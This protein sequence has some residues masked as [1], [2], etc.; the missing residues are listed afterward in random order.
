M[1][2]IRNSNPNSTQVKSGNGSVV[3]FDYG[4]PLPY[5]SN[6]YPMTE[7]HTILFFIIENTD[8]LNIIIKKNH[9]MNNK[10][11]KNKILN[12]RMAVRHCQWRLY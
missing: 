6:L 7:K 4:N 8:F 2:Y 1:T 12:L 3:K 11:D 9:I 10:S 5:E